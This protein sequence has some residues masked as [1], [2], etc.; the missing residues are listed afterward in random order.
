MNF[1]TT[2][3]PSSEKAEEI[4]EKKTSN[5]KDLLIQKQGPGINSLKFT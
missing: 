2:D 1:I 5:S 4:K 3:V